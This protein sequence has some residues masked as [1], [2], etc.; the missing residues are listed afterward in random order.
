MRLALATLTF[1]RQVSWVC[2]LGWVSL[3]AV[4][5]VLTAKLRLFAV[6]H[7]CCG[8]ANLQQRGARRF[9]ARHKLALRVRLGDRD[10]VSHISCGRD[11]R[12]VKRAWLFA[13]AR[14]DREPGERGAIVAARVWLRPRRVGLE[15]Q[16]R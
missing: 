11:W 2:L 1:G 10:L 7:P 4:V 13:I 14:Q 16:S 8:A 6:G 5:F 3:L 15:T 12:G 9:A